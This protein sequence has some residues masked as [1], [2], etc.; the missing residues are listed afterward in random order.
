MLA[1][2]EAS[3]HE[4]GIQQPQHTSASSHPKLSVLPA[5][6]EPLPPIE[7]LVVLGGSRHPLVSCHCVAACHHP[8]R[9]QRRQSL[10]EPRPQQPHASPNPA[11]SRRDYAAATPERHSV[12]K[13]TDSAAAEGAAR[14]AGRS[15]R[16]GPHQLAV[17]AH[18]DGK[19]GLERQEQCVCVGVASYCSAALDTSRRHPQ[20]KRG[21]GPA[22]V[23]HVLGG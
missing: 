10:P 13:A 15:R 7:S 8:L 20:G 4:R 22:T 21:A 19:S 2:A 23:T 11:A 17:A 3:A 1:H 16:L 6:R 9:F 5:L 12:L 18:C 14:G